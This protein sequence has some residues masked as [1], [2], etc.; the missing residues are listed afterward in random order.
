MNYL[1]CGN[2]FSLVDV[3]VEKILSGRKP[4]KYSL[5]EIAL[6]EV[7]K[8]VGYNSMF[9]E[10]K[11]IILKDFEALNS[12]KKENEKA[13]S[14]LEN[15][16]DNPNDLTT[17][18]FITKEKVPS[19]GPLK[20]IVSKLKVIETQFITKPYELA[21]KMD[22]EVRKGGY[23]IAQDAL[24]VFCEKCATNYDLAEK[25]LGK[26]IAIKG[27]D[28]MIS[29]KDVEEYV[30][31]YNTS[32]SFGFKDAVINKN[33]SKAMQLLDDLESSKMEV[34]PLVIMLAKEFEAVYNIKL[35]V[36]KEISNDQIGKEMGNMHPYRVKLLREAGNKYTLE[37]LED[38]IKYLCDLDIR[39]V[40]EDNLGYDELRKLFLEI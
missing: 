31:N 28:K 7:L 13:I 26:L 36:L 27:N 37:K 20:K 35:L 5:E 29:L 14:S 19:K 24:N 25:E 4:I 11:V 39:L 3:E 16:L 1:I 30:S 15:Y 32:D 2:S 22:E 23:S 6:G 17:L 10:E 40:S 33:L 9:E 8:D 18:I 38:I 21:K 34:L 12:S